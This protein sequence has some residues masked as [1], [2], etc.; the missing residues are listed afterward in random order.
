MAQKS[1][2]LD[3]SLFFGTVQQKQTFCEALLDLLKRRGCV[4]I[5]NHGIPDETIHEMFYQVSTH[6]KYSQLFYAYRPTDAKVFLTAATR[7]VES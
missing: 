3:M 7:Q 2:A 4:K 6:C 1:D 5:R